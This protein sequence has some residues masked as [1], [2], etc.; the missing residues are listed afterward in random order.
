MI[1]EI[2]TQKPLRIGI[3][4]LLS[5]FAFWKLPS[6]IETMS[7]TLAMSQTLFGLFFV[8]FSMHIL[9]WAFSQENQIPRGLSYGF[10]LLF[11]SFLLI[12]RQMNRHGTFLPFGIKEALSALFSLVLFTV[13]L[14]SIIAFLISK[15]SLTADKLQKQQN[16]DGESLFSRLTGNGWLILAVLFISWIPVWLSFWPGI[17]RADATWQ[18]Y[19]YMARDWNTHHPLFHTFLHGACLELGLKITGSMTIA[20]AVYSCLQMLLM[21]GIFSYSCHW[22]WK[23]KVPLVIRLSVIALFALFPVYPIWS[24]NATKDVAF[25][26]FFLL[27]L[28]QVMDWWEEDGAALRSPKRMILFIMTGLVMM[29]LRHNGIHSLLISIPFLILLSKKAW[30]LRIGL[31][32]GCTIAVY[33]LCNWCMVQT[34]QARRGSEVEAMSIPLQQ[35]ARVAIASPE[36]LSVSDM[37]SIQKIYGDSNIADIYDPQSADANKW[38]ANSSVINENFS[39]YLQLWL[40]LGLRHPR[41]YLEA[42]CEQNMAYFDPNVILYLPMTH[43]CNVME[44]Y[45]IDD[46]PILP[47]LRVAYER[48]TKTPYFLPIP[49]SF[50]LSNSAFMVWLCLLCMG[51]QFYRK[52]YSVIMSGIFLLL[53][54]GTNLLG[55]VM[56]MRYMLP[57]FY[58]VPIMAARIF[59]NRTVLRTPLLPQ[60]SKEE[61]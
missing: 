52:Q 16:L 55:P 46:T 31:L 54:L 19:E 42:F 1:K 20:V 32:C 37:E 36:T 9:L 38:A 48:F 43:G 4:F 60:A 7:R 47:R 22:L 33:M 40:R 12:G 53:F 26:G 29:L 50:L 45:P 21:A 17:F 15:I 25:G 13:L 6:I 8:A 59:G 28:L 27:L 24:L 23:R 10:G 58:C 51:I 41:I 57:F 44:D 61:P 5:I 11:T 3:A 39:E 56:L 35:L 2:F 18:F 49:G 14:G 34:L 30:R